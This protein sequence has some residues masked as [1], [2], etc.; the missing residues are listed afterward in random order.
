MNGVSL[1]TGSGIG[2]LAASH[3]GIRTVAMCESDPCCRYILSHLH[4]DTP[5][6]EDV[7]DV[8][9]ESLW[10]RGV[11]SVDII[12]GGFPCQD[13]STA[14]R[15][16]GIEGSRSGLWREMFRV[17]RQV[18]P[19][20]LCLEN[21]PVLRVRGADRVLAPLEKIGYTCW[22]LVVGAWAVGAPHKRDRVWIVGRRLDDARQEHGRQGGH[23][24]NGVSPQRT[25][26]ADFD[27]RPVADVGDSE[28]GGQ[29]ADGGTL[30]NAGHVDESDEAVADAGC[31]NNGSEGCAGSDGWTVPRWPSRPGQPQHDWESAR[32]LEFGLGDA[33]DGLPARVRSRANKA[34][35]R[36][37]GNAWCYPNAR[38]IYE[39]IVKQ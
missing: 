5:L 17:I 10:E 4:P 32:L 39:W 18:R 26:A 12:S 23:D 16:K 6:F 8:S 33:V 29:R 28:S 36:V 34:L 1:F 11:G 2:D 24:D 9:A 37:C 3:A 20:W 38:L 21:V 31:G 35:L 14:G 27:Q 15:G 13:L 30:G 19:V 22:P 7:R 25:E